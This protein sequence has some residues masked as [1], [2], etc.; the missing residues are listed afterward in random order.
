[1]TTNWKFNLIAGLLYISII[2]C[3]KNIQVDMIIHNAQVNTVDGQNTTYEALAIKDGKIVEL[4]NNDYI[5]S[6]AS[7]STEILDAKGNFV[8]P[9]FIEGH[10][11]FFSLGESLVD[12]NFL[13]D[14]SWEAIV[15]K[16]S[17]KAKTLEKGEWIVGRGWHQEKWD[18]LPS[19]A[20]EGYPFHAD[21]SS[22]TPDNP[23][24]LDHA[25]GHGIFVNQK[26]M[27]LV[28]IQNETPNPS[29]GRI[30]RDHYGRAIGI[31]EENAA[32]VF[33]K[34]YD[35]AINKRSAEEKD[36]YIKKVVD[37]AQQECLKNGVT[38]FQDAGSTVDQIAMYKDMA[39]QGKLD[40][41][42]WV[43]LYAAAS[44]ISDNI[45]D[46][47]MIDV[48]NGFFTCRAVK[49]YVDG[50]LG[51]YGAWLL[52]EY[53]DKPGFHGQNV[54]SLE[55]L[56]RIAKIVRKHDMQLCTHAIGDRANREVLNFYAAALG[57]DG[58]S[59]RWRI[60][61]AQHLHPDDIP[62]FKE[63][64]V[65]ASMQSTH[66]TSDAP[67]VEKRLGADRAAAGAYVWK[68]LI[69]SGAR[70]CNG[71]DVPVE[72][73]D[74]ISSYYALV[75]RKREDNG[76]EFYTEQSLSRIEALRA[77]TIYCA[78]AAFEEEWK[79]SLEKG[80]VADIVILDHNL[81]TCKDE[82]ILD[83]KIKYTIIDGKVKYKG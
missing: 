32:N 8:M 63:L 30:L 51:S 44:D 70:F 27:E 36:H 80:K 45:A 72:E 17:A 15:A 38:S 25:S 12:L 16:V 20:V 69:E 19:G 74:P 28:G 54:T 48:G 11:H 31:F 24:L 79:G 67:F 6:M 52:E 34:Y 75:T 73:L 60:E 10:G 77:C 37:L 40:L 65:I 59:Q 71:T 83:T 64:G 42:L 47:K 13:H 56:N 1:M 57:A 66:C 53:D 29:G 18:S 55:E 43:M 2:S 78:Y 39:E 82:E 68:S 5:L 41:R 26:A 22:L 50:A 14:K 3:Q 9:G 23:V 81:L 4:G 21:L 33:H 7:D 62:R 58:G 46:Y 35:E 49:A 61:H 76:M